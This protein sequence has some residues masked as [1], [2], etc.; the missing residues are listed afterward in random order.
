MLSPQAHVPT[1]QVVEEQRSVVHVRSDRR[2][3]QKE[4]VDEHSELFVLKQCMALF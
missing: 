1:I 4:L 2:R 3:E